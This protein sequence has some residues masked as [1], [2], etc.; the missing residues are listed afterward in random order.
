MKAIRVENGQVQQVE[1]SPPDQAG[2]MVRVSSASICGSDLHMLQMGFLEGRVP[3]HEF[4]GIT[5]DGTRVAV[6]PLISCGHCRYCEQGYSAHCDSEIQLYGVGMDGGMAELVNVPARCLVPLPSGLSVTDACLVEPLA[7]ALHGL[8]R[9]RVR[10]GDRVLVI[11]GGSIGLATAAALQSRGIAFDLQARHPHQSDAAQTLGADPEVSDGYD[12]VLDAV[13]SSQ[14]LA[15][16]ASRI[17]PLGR[18]GMLGTFWE[19]TAAPLELCMKE[20]ELLPAAMYRCH[21]PNRTFDEAGR[22][23]ADHT[24]IARTLVS[25]RFPL[26]AAPQAFE[27]AANRQAG[28]IKI[29]FEPHG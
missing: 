23:L 13:G 7:V 22:A 20:A 6:E 15:E 17:R 12:V 19:A 16:A 11:G 10:E 2:V 24:H 25:H 21:S 9:A 4:A 14:S 3:G 27:I 26:E 28:A 29:V 8:D 18:I 1:A 5:P